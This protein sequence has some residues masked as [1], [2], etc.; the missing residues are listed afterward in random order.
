MLPEW[1]TAAAG[2]VAFARDILLFLLL[3]VLVLVMVMVYVKVSQLLEVIKRTAKSTEDMVNMV[4]ENLAKPA[5]AG[6]GSGMRL[7]R[8]IGLVIGLLRR[9][10]NNGG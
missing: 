5:I 8:I 4:S 6:S 3:L 7:G 9:K 2:I 10:K 1:F